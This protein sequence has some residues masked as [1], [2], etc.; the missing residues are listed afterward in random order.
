VPT[1]PLPESEN[2]LTWNWVH[3]LRE[4]EGL[5]QRLVEFI[6]E[7]CALPAARFVEAAYQP[8]LDSKKT[9]D[10]MLVTDDWSILFEHKIDAPL[11]PR[12]L[13]D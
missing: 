13:Q 12:Q 7:R 4:V 5:G 8:R 6:A 2:R 9:P 1:I 10:C 11:G 3:A